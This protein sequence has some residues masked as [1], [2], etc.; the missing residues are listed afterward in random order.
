MAADHRFWHYIRY[1]CF[2][3]GSIPRKLLESWKTAASDN[4]FDLCSTAQTVQKLR[5]NLD[6]GLFISLTFLSTIGFAV[7]L[8]QFIGS[9]FMM[10]MYVL[11]MLVGCILLHLVICRLLKI[12]YEYVVLSMVGCIVD[13][14][15][16]SLTAAGANWK[17]LINV[18]LIM[19]V[20]AGA[21][22]NHVGIFVAYTVRT[23]CGL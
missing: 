12:K 8:Q 20:L 3:S 21:A 6:L 19:G 10:T 23:I 22:G 1:Y 18:G 15:T 16:S 14:P 2:F 9:A 7:D 13:G 5:G 11:C 4:Y 17:S